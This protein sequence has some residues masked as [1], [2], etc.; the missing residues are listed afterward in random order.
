MNEE[1]DLD[2]NFWPS[3]AD[4]MLTLVLIL[5]MVLSVFVIMIGGE[6][7]NIKKASDSQQHLVTQI[8]EKYPDTPPHPRENISPYQF[9]QPISITKEGKRDIIIVNDL[10]RQV[11][12]FSDNILFE[13]GK[14]YISDRGREVLTIVG[15]TIV[16]NLDKIQRIQIEGHTD[17]VPFEGTN[18]RLG[19]NRAIAVFEFFRSSAVGINPEEHLMSAT[20]FG[21]WKPVNRSEDGKSFDLTRLKAANSEESRPKNR[22]VELLLIYKK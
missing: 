10:D 15:K 16:D 19:A 8:L 21:E 12:T 9:A 3:L 7:V 5:I 20:S 22:R 14:D 1:Y 13:S 18:L 17:T 4:M 6:S 11:I 2:F